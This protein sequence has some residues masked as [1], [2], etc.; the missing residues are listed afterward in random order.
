[1][2]PLGR[3]LAS[4]IPRRH[5][6]NAEDII[7]QIDSMEA[8]GDEPENVRALRGDEVEEDIEEENTDE[9][10]WQETVGVEEEPVKVEKKKVQVVEEM[11]A[12][13]IEE[14]VPEPM[15]AKPMVTPLTIEVEPD[16]KDKE[17]LAEADN[18]TDEDKESEAEEAKETIA[19]EKVEPLKAEKRVKANKEEEQTEPKKTVKEKV[20]AAF[21]DLAAVGER[22]VLGEKVEYITIGDIEVNPLQPRRAFDEEDL[23][24]LVQSLDQHGMLQPLV[25]AK[26]PG[27][28]MYQLVAGERRWRASKRLGWEK[29]PCVIRSD[30]SSDRHRLELALT[31]NVQRQNLNPVEEAMGYQRLNEEYGMT[32]EEIGERVGRSR[33]GITNIIRLLQ[34]PAEI[35]RGL[36]ESKISIGHARAILMIPDE[37]KQIRFYNHVVDEGLTVRKA[38]NRARRVQ[39]TMK[40]N[41][42]LRKKTRGRPQLALKYDGMLQDKFGY[43]ARVM[44]KSDKNRFEVVFHAFSEDEAQ[45]LIE[46]LLGLQPLPDTV[47]QDVIED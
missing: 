15:P 11:E 25:V 41:D 40:L 12:D 29:V 3:G 35:Q 13:V 9:I 14:T 47:D 16:E 6:E 36:I 30:V 24:D 31:E 42:P 34:L 7:E 43:N 2:T 37:E 1:M 4:L 10:Q 8:V 20:A 44:F 46:R 45:E 21:D 19:A 18:E 39:R 33:V 17:I 23:E 5:K 38:E 26:M 28:K 27:Q 32:H 22:R